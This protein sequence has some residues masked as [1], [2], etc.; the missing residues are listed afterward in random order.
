M[1]A[2]ERS[3][4]TWIASGRENEIENIVAGSCVC[5]TCIESVLMGV[6]AI[7]AGEAT[8]LDVVKALREFLTAEEDDVRN[9]G[10]SS[11]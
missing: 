1:S 5:F 11:A 6:A 7:S 10:L 2:V 3:V 4:R 9:K 8:L